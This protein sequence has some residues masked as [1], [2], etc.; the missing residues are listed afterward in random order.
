MLA[1]VAESTG[2]CL[3]LG[4]C[5]FKLRANFIMA[6]HAESSRCGHGIIDLQ[7]MVRRMTTKAITGHLAC[8]M[9]L[10][11]AGTVRNLTMNLVAEGAGLFGMRALVLSKILPRTL[12][13]GQARLFYVSSQMQGQW[14]MGVGVTG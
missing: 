14:F 7:R 8:G 4:G 9:G 12:M 3:V 6:S 5:F 1:A 10:M 13:T 11:T 2:K